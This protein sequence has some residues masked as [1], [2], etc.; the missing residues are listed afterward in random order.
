MKHVSGLV[1]CLLLA[2]A[3]EVAAQPPEPIGPLVVNVRGS[4]ARLKAEPPVADALGVA[5]AALPTRGLGPSAG[6]HWYPLRRGRVTLG[7][8]GELVLARGRGTAEETDTIVGRPAVT[9]RFSDVSPQISLNFGT[10]DG[11]SYISG[12]I[13]R[14]RLTT[15]SD[16]LPPFDGSA[17]RIR[18]TN[19]GGGARWFTSPRVAFTFDVRFYTIDA[20]DPT[21][22]QPGYPRNRFMVISVGTSLR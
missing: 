8:G 7:V 3:D 12:G 15:E 17:A 22:V 11:W 19:Y 1:L 13:G 10:N 21:E 6:V 20:R 18:S 4:L 14:A 5:T 9:T 2:G 16:A